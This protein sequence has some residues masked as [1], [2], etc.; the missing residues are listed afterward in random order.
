M[1]H[2]DHQTLKAD[3]A[4][5]P[6]AD[7]D[8]F[9]IQYQLRAR[10]LAIVELSGRIDADAVHEF[11]RTIKEIFHQSHYRLVLD[12]TRVSYITSSGI[13]VIASAISEAQA[14]GGDIVLVKPTTSISNLVSLLGLNELVPQADSI[15]EALDNFNWWE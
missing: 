14:N 3:V 7:V 5:T 2:T 6:T 9:E 4:S 11:W 8:S 1:M 10:G 12:C 15:N 13:G